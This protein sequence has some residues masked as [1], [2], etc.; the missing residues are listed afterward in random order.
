MREKINKV[1]SSFESVPSAGHQETK[2][3]NIEKKENLN[4]HTKSNNFKIRWEVKQTLKKAVMSLDKGD[5]NN[6]DYWFRKTRKNQQS[7]HKIIA[8]N[9]HIQKIKMAECV[10]YLFILQLLI[11]LCTPKKWSF[12]HFVSFKQQKWI[13]LRL[14]DKLVHTR[15]MSVLLLASW[16]IIISILIKSQFQCYFHLT[17]ITVL[18]GDAALKKQD[19]IWEE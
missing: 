7:S 13:H 5:K 9:H 1:I 17:Q 10:L 4:H 16:V 18:S 8:A 15:L 12:V 11:L 14:W 3:S 19:S 6:Q 2:K